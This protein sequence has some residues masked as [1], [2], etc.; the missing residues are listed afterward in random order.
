MKSNIKGKPDIK[1]NNSKI[2]DQLKE[3]KALPKKT[4]P[5]GKAIRK[6]LRRLGYYLSKVNINKESK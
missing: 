1:G 5:K 3:Y 4:L 2:K 6:R